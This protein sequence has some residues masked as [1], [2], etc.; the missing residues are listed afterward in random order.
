MPVAT[1][2]NDIHFSSLTY[3]YVTILQQYTSRLSTRYGSPMFLAVHHSG[4]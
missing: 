2:A 4:K 3:M 1:S